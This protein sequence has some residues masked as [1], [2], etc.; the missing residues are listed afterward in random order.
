MKPFIFSLPPQNIFARK[1]KTRFKIQYIFFSILPI[2]LF[3][4]RLIFFFLLLLSKRSWKVTEATGNARQLLCIFQLSKSIYHF[5]N[6]LSW[7]AAHRHI[8]ITPKNHLDLPIK[9][10]LFA[11]SDRYKLVVTNGMEFFSF[12]F[13]SK[14]NKKIYKKHLKF[15]R[16]VWR[17]KLSSYLHFT[18]VINFEFISICKRIYD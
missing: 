10:T 14:K 2:L 6:T 8:S 18:P 5:W 12:S 9:I 7:K 17:I 1:K 11:R 4:V 16:K 3:N 15:C 13:E